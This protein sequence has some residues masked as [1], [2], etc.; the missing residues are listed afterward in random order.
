MSTCRVLCGVCTCEVLPR[1]SFIDSHLLLLLLLLREELMGSK[2]VSFNLELAVVAR[3]L[4]L[5]GAAVDPLRFVSPVLV[6]FG[7]HVELLLQ[8]VYLVVLDNRLDDSSHIVLPIETFKNSR[9]TVQLSVV[10]VVEP[11]NGRNSILSLEKV[12]YR[13]VVNDDDVFHG[14]AQP[15]QILDEGVVVES[16]VLSEKQV[17][18][19]LLRVKV[20]HQRLSIL[21]QTRSKDYKLVYFVHLFEEL[22]DKGPHKNVDWL[23]FTID[24]YRQND[25]SVLDRLKRRVHQSFV[26]VKHQGFTTGLRC[27]LWPQQVLILKVLILLLLS[28]MGLIAGLGP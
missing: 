21:R 6:L 22:G 11:G 28:L 16:A 20:F 25:I 2:A 4:G 17:G 3:W 13:G 18:T 24:F 5:L 10:G 27:S 15:R 7:D 14:A 23:D 26:E 1:R 8:G 9:D 19:H 12:S